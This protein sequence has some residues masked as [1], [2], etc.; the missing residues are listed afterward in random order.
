MNISKISRSLV[1]A[2]FI[3]NIVFFGILDFKMLVSKDQEVTSQF[4]NLTKLGYV[5]LVIIL[6][7]LYIYIKDK[8]YKKKI[9]RKVGL[10]FRYIYVS[11]VLIASKIGIVYLQGIQFTNK[12][13][14]TYVLISFITG[15]IIKK[16]IFN[17]SKSDMLSVLAT[18]SYA[19]LPSSV[20]LG[21]GLILASSFS[22][23]FFAGLLTLQILI[24]ELKQRGIK[25]QKYVV[26]S[27]ILGI[28]IGVSMVF[29]I[30]PCVWIA[31]AIV[32]II[33]ASNLDNTH[34]SFPKKMMDSISQKGRERLYTIERI[35]I[36]KLI[37]SICVV[38]IFAVTI[39]FISKFMLETF[40]NKQIDNYY[41]NSIID[42]FNK[43][44][45]LN[46]VQEKS[47]TSL[48][49][50]YNKFI[51]N[52]KTFY[53]FC[54]IYIIFMEILA[55]ALKRRYDTKST[56]M[57]ALFLFILNSIYLF[58]LNVAFYEPL[59]TVLIVLIA[60]V[61]TSNIYLNREERVK[62]LVA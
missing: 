49:N 29:G 22:L 52:Y 35:N 18:F 14:I 24:D 60:I 48:S 36:N 23:V 1:V 5:A 25:T 50:F 32:S 28:I 2:I 19:L 47:I 7:L 3:V 17:V 61:N 30:N 54:I 6:V 8:L 13:F 10:V 12:E 26:E 15:I 46:L 57:K 44:N 51:S 42:T 62:M 33:V 58:N 16:I 38:F 21:S 41:I 59:L 53:M 31:F 37:V 9:K 4:T 45:D 43:N 56:M 40:E 55:I 20:V 39:Y 27:T 34:I 11:I